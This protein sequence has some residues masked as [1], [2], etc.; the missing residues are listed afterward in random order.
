MSDLSFELYSE[1]R[2]DDEGTQQKAY[3]TF[4]KDRLIQRHSSVQG[5]ILLHCNSC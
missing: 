2:D 1:Y 5:P 4:F 3:Q